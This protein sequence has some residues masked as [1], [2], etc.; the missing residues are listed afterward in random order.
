MK[1]KTHIILILILLP[2]ICFAK[3]FNFGEVWLKCSKDDRLVWAWGFT[4]GQELILE[5]MKVKSKD[6]LKYLMLVKDA[7]VISKIMT[8]YYNDASNTYTP[9]K[10][11][12]YI[13]KMKLEGKSAQRIEKELESFREYA[14][15]LRSK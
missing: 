10:Y 15:Y 12:T 4:N 5:E 6:N 3:D 14:T 2:T 1:I 9:W 13:A 8:Q 11:M 7:Q